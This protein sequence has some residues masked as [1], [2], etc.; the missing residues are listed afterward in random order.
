MTKRGIILCILSIVLAAYLAFGLAYA[1]KQDAVE[2]YKELKI[3]MSEETFITPAVIDERLGYLSARIASLPA[4]SINT[5]QIERLVGSMDN[6][7]SVRCLMLNDRTVELDVVPL[8]PVARVFDLSDN[9]SFYINAQGKRMSPRP[10]YFND[11]PVVVGDFSW[12]DKADPRS[13]IPVI[14]YLETDTAMAC[15]ISSITISRKGDIY[16][17]PMMRGHVVAFGDTT[18]IADKMARLRVFY[19]RVLPVKG[20]EHYDTISVKWRGQVVATRAQKSKAAPALPVVDEYDD[21]TF[22]NTQ[23]ESPNF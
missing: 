16:L 11:V 14:R 4:D 8:I 20:W 7:E 23:G 5:L 12:A 15:L 22:A 19:R 6:V 17:V 21:D 10:D 1:Y 3:K 13:A 2:P 18:D 9:S